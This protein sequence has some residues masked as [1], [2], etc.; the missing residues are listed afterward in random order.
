MTRFSDLTIE[1]SGVYAIFFLIS[2]LKLDQTGGFGD[3]PIEQ[4]EVHAIFCRCIPDKK[5]VF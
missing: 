1:R 3:L 5:G 2:E 4:P